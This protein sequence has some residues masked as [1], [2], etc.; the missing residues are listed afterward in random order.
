MGVGR[1]VQP[2][3]GGRPGV[4]CACVALSEGSNHPGC[5]CLT[6]GGGTGFVADEQDQC[7]ALDSQSLDM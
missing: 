1:D 7:N 5:D 2:T 3:V 4:A 6:G